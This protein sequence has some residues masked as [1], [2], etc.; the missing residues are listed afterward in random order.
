MTENVSNY[1]I[2]KYF[3]I[4]KIKKKKTYVCYGRSESKN[5]CR[6]ERISNG[7][8]WAEIHEGI[9]TVG[10]RNMASSEL[11]NVTC[12]QLL[13]WLQTQTGHVCLCWELGGG[14]KGRL[15]RES[16]G[17]LRVIVWMYGTSN[18]MGYKTCYVGR[19]SA[20]A[21]MTVVGCC[22]IILHKTDINSF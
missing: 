17:R 21:I 20:V 12:C 7:K 15:R 6:K 9:W 22:V 18:W 3:I 1:D 13:L 11:Q 8:H 5:C 14:G 10:F 19:I 16:D 4:T 2:P